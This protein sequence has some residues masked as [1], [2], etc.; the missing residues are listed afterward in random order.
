MFGNT[1]TRMFQPYSMVLDAERALGMRDMRYK[2][3]E[4]EP[5]LSGGGAFVKGFMLPFASRGYLSRKEEADAPV[6]NFPMMGEKRRLGPTWKLALGINIEQ[7]D[8]EWQKHLKSLQYID[9]DFASKTGIDIID[10][11][12]NALHNEL[13]PD[14]A[15]M[16][17][18]N[19][20]ALKARLEK[21]GR[22]SPKIFLMEQR[23]HIENN[24]RKM[25]ESVKGAQ[26]SGSS[27]P[28]Y[29]MAVNEFRRITRDR[30][31]LAMSELSA[32]KAAR[33][34]PPVNL[35]DIGDLN[36]LIKI[37]KRKSK[38]RN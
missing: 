25:F 16:S 4:G 19:A 30:R 14:I 12:M 8:N 7:G 24:K 36:T 37:A 20:P 15:K 38:E 28:P 10:N 1:L 22:Y 26:Y 11:T 32:M 17:M 3:Y 33:G 18:E 31:V 6:R 9:Y 27:N 13:L 21:E 35:G 23:N 29:V 34:E 2:T 5:N